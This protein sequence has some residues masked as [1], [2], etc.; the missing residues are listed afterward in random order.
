MTD[1]RIVLNFSELQL[2]IT[3]LIALGKHTDFVC[4]LVLFSRDRILGSPD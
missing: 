3:L 4:L 1:P 2:L